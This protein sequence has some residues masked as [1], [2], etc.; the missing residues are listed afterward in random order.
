MLL[1]FFVA[2]CL[3]SSRI[4]A[5]LVYLL[6]FSLF[7]PRHFVFPLS[8][9]GNS[10]RSNTGISVYSSE[11]ITHALLLKDYSSCRERNAML[12]PNTCVLIS[13]D[14]SCM[15][16]W[17]YSNNC[18]IILLGQCCL[19]LEYLV[20]FFVFSFLFAKSTIPTGPGT[21]IS[22]SPR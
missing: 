8:V 20:F 17:R 1:M 7:S 22:S 3:L 9:R 13:I 10:R 4:S 12:L 14:N 2:V 11:S 15:K 19:L 16:A 5:I 21:K 18:D 6:I